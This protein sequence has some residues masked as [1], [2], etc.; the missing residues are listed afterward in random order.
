[1]KLDDENTLRIANSLEDISW[2]LNKLSEQ[3]KP[4]CPEEERLLKEIKWT[5]E[6]AEQHA[7]ELRSIVKQQGI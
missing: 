3:Y 2:F 1:M 6:L 4:N 5:R 7:L